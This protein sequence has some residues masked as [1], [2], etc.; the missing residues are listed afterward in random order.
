MFLFRKNKKKG[1]ASDG[2]ASGIEA[3]IKSATAAVKQEEPAQAQ[4]RK[5]SRT[6]SKRRSSKSRQKGKAL[7]LAPAEQKII[8]HVRGDVIGSDVAIA[9]PFGHRELVYCDYVASGRALKSVEQ[10]IREHVLT[11]YA[12]THTEASLTGRRTNHLREQ[13]RS[14]IARSCGVNIETH[15][16]IF[17]G[18]NGLSL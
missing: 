3:T 14:V 17:A 11:T 1:Q 9:T 10:F 16:V 7:K 4:Q 13:A 5:S 15:A 8:D 12:N 2:S 6:K 18:K